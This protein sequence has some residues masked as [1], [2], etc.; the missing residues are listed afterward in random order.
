MKRTAP[1]VP[2][3]SRLARGP[4]AMLAPVS[5]SLRW[6]RPRPK[7][8]S[9]PGSAIAGVEGAGD[10]PVAGADG[11]VAAERQV[12]A[13]ARDVG[14]AVD[15]VVR[16]EGPQPRVV[17]ERE[18]PGPHRRLRLHPRRD[19]QVAVS[20][21]VRAVV[22]ERVRV[23]V[24]RGHPGA[25][26]EGPER[27]ARVVGRHGGLGRDRRLPGGRRR[28]GG[29]ELR[30]QVGDGR[31]L[32]G[33]R[34]L[35]LSAREESTCEIGRHRRGLAGRYGRRGRRGRGPGCRG[36][37]RRCDR[38]ATH[39]RRRRRDERRRVGRRGGRTSRMDQREGDARRGLG[40]WRERNRWRRLHHRRERGRGGCGGWC[41]H[42]RRDRR[43]Q[44]FGRGHGSRHCRGRG[45]RS[46]DERRRR[47]HG[48]LPEQDEQ[49]VRVAPHV[50]RRVGRQL[51]ADAHLRRSRRDLQPVEPRRS[52]SEN[53]PLDALRRPAEPASACE[54]QA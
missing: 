7:K 24:P 5:T 31:R 40:H 28:A 49:P 16:R 30:I 48:S 26:A 8:Y 53:L 33:A 6:K 46:R 47:G 41:A 38:G 14:A 51:H 54:A 12:E 50:D 43:G 45:G 29:E 32:A 52:A 37:R 3:S 35:G 44:R 4:I 25:H 10:E 42:S 11:H 15:L 21:R 18:A 2:A 13:D 34:R 9:P 1:A 20:C 17:L 23:D 39:G 22:D 27:E 19:L 36:V